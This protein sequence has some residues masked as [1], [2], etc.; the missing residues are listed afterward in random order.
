MKAENRETAD[1]V[2]ARID[3]MSFSPAWLTGQVA[4]VCGMRTV[5][6]ETREQQLCD[7]LDERTEPVA[8]RWVE[9]MTH[10]DGVPRF[11]EE[12]TYT[13]WPAFIESVIVDCLAELGYGVTNAAGSGNP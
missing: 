7:A 13:D 4:T 12:G 9:A 1:A 8:R 11:F 2:I 3:R 10:K 6:R 5:D